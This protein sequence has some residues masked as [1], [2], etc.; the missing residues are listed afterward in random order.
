MERSARVVDWIE[1]NVRA[2]WTIRYTSIGARRSTDFEMVTEAAQVAEDLSPLERNLLALRSQVMVAMAGLPP[3]ATSATSEPLERWAATVRRIL[4]RGSAPLISPDLEHA[5]GSRRDG[6]VSPSQVASAFIGP[7]THI[8]L[9][10]SIG[11]HETW[12]APFWDIL[13]RDYPSLLRW[14]SPQ[15]SHEGLMGQRD[16]DE[17][18][19][20]VD[21][22]LDVP[23]RDQPVVL[24]IDG[25]G[26]TTQKAIDKARDQDLAI[27][28]I[29][30]R[31]VNGP[32]IFDSEAGLREALRRMAS[33]APITPSA[34]VIRFLLAPTLVHR[35]AFAIS[36]LAERNALGDG[37]RWNV[38][39]D[40]GLG[41]INAGIPWMLEFLRRID[42][43][44]AGGIVPDSVA[45]NGQVWAR[46]SD[47]YEP[48][49]STSEAP[50]GEIQLEPFLPPHHRLQEPEL[51]TVVIRSAFLPHQPAWWP[52][53][54]KPRW[55]LPDE[56]SGTIERGLAGLA[57][58][59]YGYPD[60]RGGQ[61]N[62][63]LQVLRGRDSVV[64]LPTGSGKSLIYQLSAL[65]RPGLCLVIDPI[66]ALIDDQ[67][68]RFLDVGI[69]RIAA[70]HSASGATRADRALIQARVARG[71]MLFAFVTPERL[72]NVE[73]RES[74]R[75][76]AD[77]ISVNLAVVD[78]AHCVSEW[79]HD[80][81][82][83]FLRLGMNLR[84]FGMDRW[85]TPPPVLALTG[86]ASP[87]VL[88]DTLI[89]L[90][91]DRSSPGAVQRPHSFDRRNL[92]YGVQMGEPSERTA[93]VKA[94][95]QETIPELL[96][97]GSID[98]TTSG[99][100]FL[101]NTSGTK[102][103]V[104]ARSTLLHNEILGYPLTEDDVGIFSGSVPTT[105]RGKDK[106]P[107]MP[108]NEWPA[109]K[110]RAARAFIRG[111]V[112]ILVATKAFGMGIDK[113]DI[114]F[115]I[116]IGYPS[117]IEAFAQESG[118]AGRD[119]QPSACVVVGL[120]APEDVVKRAVANPP[121]KAANGKTAWSDHDW[122]SQEYFLVNSFPGVTQETAQ[123][124]GL[125]R[126]LRRLGAKGLGE[127]KV[128]PQI[129]LADGTT[130]RT[131]SRE[132]V[133]SEGAG[134][135][136]VKRLLYRLTNVGV[137]DDISYVGGGNMKIDFADFERAD[138]RTGSPRIDEALL[139]F[140]ARNDPGRLRAHRREIAS[141]PDDI[142]AR[143]EHHIRIAVHAVYNVIRKAR[144]NA[145]EA[146]DR[147]IRENPSDE[148]MRTRIVAY[149]GQGPMAEAL[150]DLT[151]D[152]RRLS[153]QEAIRRFSA[154]PPSDDY[155]W[156]GAADRMLESSPNH[157]LVLTISAL[158]EFRLPTGTLERFEATVVKMLA[159][160]RDS[161]ASLSEQVDLVAWMLQNIR[162]GTD[163]ERQT[164]A[165][166][167][168]TSL[169][170]THLA[171][172]D[173]IRRLVDKVLERAKADDFVAEE[174]SG[175][176][177]FLAS[178][179]RRI[180]TESFKHLTNGAKSG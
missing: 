3:A 171:P 124:I 100:V 107:I 159:S 9:D 42:D 27:H 35:A 120:L 13:I 90:E 6:D 16:L 21:F 134:A 127:L 19:H 103:V 55:N 89:A 148:V 76:V 38:R 44:V 1:R 123:T 147:L 170:N 40:D 167:V 50:R 10:E 45:I 174:I 172:R 30:A 143:I 110:R 65:L 39:I 51:P 22:L 135:L 73:F 132:D 153:I 108:P 58:D 133:G 98:A 53:I 17:S 82:P 28:G 101:P 80:F 46:T 5:L 47:G 25:S 178:R 131:Q 78:E 156:R 63:I 88:N 61:L 14:I 60:F 155:E 122:G 48:A 109:E 116:H 106:V 26:H 91:I 96:G 149:L 81:R 105:G 37:D 49:G 118:R 142:D 114:R 164:W 66:T 104:E 115:T 150:D 74:L 130:Y 138:R 161:D 52:E 128:P 79:G 87:R 163:P 139:D 77:E 64:L 166:T 141:A 93:L 144:L 165:G 137:V 75:E 121:E 129:R 112:P 152:D 2:G 11:L 117:S 29:V 168:W 102:G 83:A 180:T 169:A 111:Q 125:F 41:V 119:E 15:V 175:L 54:R 145:L 140:L 43:V 162:A 56:P 20:W 151:R 70:L 113:P 12:E 99:I 57:R 32:T 31:R 23:W 34:E 7:P 176:E 33:E 136:D 85:D 36:L 173:E 157:P 94:A 84:R 59:V 4:Q 179:A 67:E 8:R 154:N 72:Q 68:R 62:A 18:S 69:D 158:G 95:V 160:L 71:D 24:E 146:M 92:R 126:E 177:G 86:T 97:V